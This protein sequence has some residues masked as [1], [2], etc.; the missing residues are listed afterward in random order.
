MADITQRFSIDVS[1][2]VQALNTLN[3]QL[4][5]FG[6]KLDS[7][8]GRMN[9]FNKAARDAFNL[10]GATKNAT[11]GANRAAAAFNSLASSGSKAAQAGK[12]I[13]AG[14]NA[15]SRGLGL[16]ERNAKR[17]AGAVA[18]FGK[19]GNTAFKGLFGS[20]SQLARVFGTRIFVQAFGAI[21]QAITG[22]IGAFREFSQRVREVGTILPTTQRNADQLADSVRRLS[23]NFGLPINAV[24]EGLYQAVS[25]QIGDAAESLQFLESAA[26][27]SK[28]AVTDIDTSVN[29]LSGALNA[30]GLSAGNTDRVASQLFKTIENGRTRASEL[31]QSLG[32]ILPVAS[33]LGISLE[34]VL[35]GFSTITIAGIKTS[36]ATTQLR[37]AL[38]ALLK[39][40]DATKELLAELGFT[41]GE[42]FVQANGLAGAFQI[43]KDA[44]GGSITELSK[45]I[46]RVR[47][48]NAALILAG[49]GADKFQQDLQ[50]LR[51]AAERDLTPEFE[52]VFETNAERVART[53]NE[54]KNVLTVDL[55]GALT[56]VVAKFTDLLGGTTNITAA[57]KAFVPPLAAAVAI[58]TTVGTVA[59]VASKAF[60]VLSTA[61]AL[62]GT[63]VAALAGPLAL[64]L[65]PLAA[66]AA[67]EFQTQREIAQ[68]NELNAAARDA[69]NERLATLRKENAARIT[70]ANARSRELNAIAQKEIAEFNKGFQERVKAAKKANDEI[71][72]DQ[73]RVVKA[74]VKAAESIANAT[75][76]RIDKE[77][78]IQEKS[79][80]NAR[81]AAQELSDFEFNTRNKNFGQLQQF[82]NLQERANQQRREAAE[83]ARK[84]TSA[85]ATE[86]DIERARAAIERAQATAEEAQSIADQT[87]N[88]AAQ[89]QIENTLRD[90]LRQ[91]LRSENAIT[92]ASEQREAVQRKLLAQQQRELQTLQKRA[93]AVLEAPSLFDE[94]TGQALEGEARDKALEQRAK[95]L[96]EF[97]NAIK[98][99]KALSVTELLKFGGLAKQLEDQ[100]QVAD[101]NKLSVKSEAF[102]G[103]QK[104]IQ[105]NL[106]TFEARFGGIIDR[107]E[108]AQD[109]TISNPG[110]LSQALTAQLQ[111]EKI[112]LQLEAEADESVAAVTEEVN[113][114]TEALENNQ[115]A[116]KTFTSFL[117]DTFAE[118][119]SQIAG[120]DGAANLRELFRTTEQRAGQFQGIDPNVALDETQAAALKDLINDLRVLSQIDNLGFK[121]DAARIA[122]LLPPLENILAKQNQINES[123]RNGAA[124]RVQEGVILNNNA[125]AALEAEFGGQADDARREFQERKKTTDTTQ[126]TTQNLNQAEG[127]TNNQVAASAQIANNWQ[128]AAQASGQ[129]AQNAANAGGAAT[130]RIGRFF[131]RFLAGGGF[132]S[133][134]TDT[135]PAMLSPGEFVVNARSTKKFFSQLQAINAGRQ[136]IYRQDGGPV[137]NVGDINVTVGA[138]R[139]GASTGRQIA[140]SIRRELRR[141]T[142]SL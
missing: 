16:I 82:S 89:F 24:T 114:L 70:L 75:Q 69:S 78:K 133:R 115:K 29:L 12:S 96:T 120:T 90:I 17:A 14:A 103:L 5:G 46:P 62:L 6:A 20:V 137:T 66:F 128:L 21:Q 15:S 31:A 9:A 47:G 58:I 1:G 84:A 59:L 25:N 124:Q 127:S 30:F 67:F 71:I 118:A 121:D 136:P 53:F 73:E 98:N 11:D 39:P 65:A 85:G 64:L 57:I 76:K 86:Q 125:K 138:E 3:S 68:L 49:S 141:G 42:A 106:D 122:A 38:N 8:V 40:T 110:E 129:V 63:S 33:E 7:L 52:F 60:T 142:S 81:D 35:A 34:E 18:S 97:R 45:F 22:S 41:S 87:G 83:L 92:R 139:D 43:L 54:L 77:N 2:A 108:L 132:A 28:V 126:Q 80:D 26:K 109:I 32:R 99:S 113:L 101:L 19:L 4:D 37:G 13:A 56:E 111:R 131:P 119:A 44:A 10:G 116:A 95:A 51:E 94:D 123:V 88:R 27:F 72:E 23:D 93:K 61:A 79:R 104:Q 36:E 100:F 91:K 112:F 117:G 48:L 134:G 107:L 74:V 102:V 135:I 50:D 130:A 140:R 55:G 105:D